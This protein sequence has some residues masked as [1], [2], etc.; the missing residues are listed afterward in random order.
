M[1]HFFKFRSIKASLAL[2]AIAILALSIA[3]FYGFLK[4]GSPERRAQ[5]YYEHGV[6]LA[7][8]SDYARAVLELRNALRLKSNLLPAWRKLAQ[9]EET[10][11]QWNGLAES[12]HSIVSLAPDDIEAR[13]K[14]AKL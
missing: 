2:V 13:L 4:Y 3:S 1:P 7:D 10:T 12:L 5:S 8:Q 14:L 6:R 11:Q 9:V